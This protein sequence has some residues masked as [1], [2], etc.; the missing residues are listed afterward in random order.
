MGEAV[1]QETGLTKKE[2]LILTV[3]RVFVALTLFAIILK[4]L[5]I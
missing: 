2:Q 4:I 3:A 5:F 1:N